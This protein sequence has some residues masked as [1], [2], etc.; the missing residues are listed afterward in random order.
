VS[1]TVVAQLGSTPCS[2]ATCW[3]FINDGDW[4][5]PSVTA[6]CPRPRSRG[7]STSLGRARTPAHSG[8]GDG[9]SKNVIDSN[10]RGRPIS[11]PYPSAP[12]HQPDVGPLQQ[13]R[14]RHL[15]GLREQQEHRYGRTAVRPLDGADT[16]LA[17]PT[18]TAC[19]FLDPQ[20]QLGLGQSER[21]ARRSNVTC[22]RLTDLTMH[23]YRPW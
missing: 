5:A 12:L 17:Q 20:T 15:Q 9:G 21:F 8:Q 13:R 19:R 1:C 4:C 6:R 2:G 11:V 7:V 22:D 16:G 23:C 3:S 10:P 18:P 14:N